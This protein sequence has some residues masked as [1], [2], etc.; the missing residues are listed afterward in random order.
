MKHNFT[1]KIRD[2][3]NKFLRYRR[4]RFVALGGLLVL[5]IAGVAAFSGGN[6]S[7]ARDGYQLT[8][9][10]RRGPLTV[11]VKATGEIRSTNPNK[12]VPGIK[13]QATIKFLVAEGT[14]VK[15]G[16]VVASLDTEDIKRR[17]LDLE[18]KLLEQK[19]KLNVAQ[20]QMEIQIL[21]NESNLKKAEQDL[22]EKEMELDKFYMGAALIDQYKAE[23]KK[24]NVEAELL[25]KN[26]IYD[27]YMKLQK[28]GLSSDF[29]VEEKK[30][31]YGKVYAEFETA[32]L[33]LNQLEEYDFWINETKRRGEV[34]KAKTELNKTKKANDTNLQSKRQEVE[35]AKRALEATE[36]DLKSAREELEAFEV[37]A[38]FDSAVM[39]G[40]ANEWWSRRN[41]QVGKNLSPGQ[42][43]V[44]LPDMGSLQAVVNVPE[45]DIHKLQVGQEV[46][47]TI[48]AAGGKVISGKVITVSEV[49]N[50]GESW[51]SSEV[52]EFK[53][54]ISLADIKGLKPGLSCQADII[55]DK[56]DSALLLPVQA[57]F[58]DANRQ[59]VNPEKGGRSESDVL[60]WMTPG[61]VVYPEK[62]GRREVSIGKSSLREVEISGDIKPGTKVLLMPPEDSALE[63]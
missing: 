47:I 37:R 46:N 33:E 11:S 29:E 48:E 39:Y 61:Y 3:K 30:L 10:A 20:T 35:T 21:D 16:D 5:F 63:R 12:V 18:S 34:D 38:P 27:Q 17:I 54:E 28:K 2:L 32:R 59:A 60:T 7:G 4:W 50:T 31:D 36:K 25:R 40:D 45:T 52:K 14:R 24:E 41:I 51:I 58:R 1:S 9:E 62:G 42:V 57:V 55:V 56:I 13:R 43:L 22:V 19:S 53:V 6:K 23:S 26:K 15:K 49:A 8:A 44:S